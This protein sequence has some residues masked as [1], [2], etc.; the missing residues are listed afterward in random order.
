MIKS[1]EFINFRNIKGK[2]DF[3]EN[4]NVVIGPNNSGKSNLLDGIRLAFSAITGEYF[5]LSQSDFLDSDDTKNIEIKVELTDGA[6]PTF[7]YYCDSS[8]KKCGFIVNIKK[9]QSGRYV[10]EISL[11]NGSNVDYDILRD[12]V[13]IPNVYMIPLLR[14]DEIYTNGLTTGI[15]KFIESEEKYQSLKQ[16]SKNK[17][18]SLLKDKVTKFQDL[19]QKFDQ[20]LDIE[21]SEPKISDEKV[22]IV[23]N[24]QK[25]HN[26]KIGSGY[27][28][29]ANIILN[30]MND[31]Y[32][33]ILIDEI[34][35]HLHPSLIRTLIRELREIIDINYKKLNLNDENIKK[36]DVFL[37]PGR[38]E[39]LMS[40]KIILVEGYTEELL[41][42]NYLYSNNYNWSI[43]NVAG[44]M[45]EPYIE[46]ALYLNKKLVVISDNDKANSSNLEYSPRF[47]K[48]Q[49]LCLSK[50]V[51]LLEIDNTLETDLFENGFLNE[52][53]DL[54][55]S[56]KNHEQIKI[57]KPKCKIK[58]AMKLIEN[59]VN[60][61][62]W[63]VIE[64]I[65]NEFEGN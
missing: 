59:K 23:E 16:E 10:K 31:N 45:F 14:I 22:Y 56:H 18:K 2:Y 51:T 13:K 41:L 19:C 44:V 28:S 64:G 12:D 49:S 32:N 30:T 26:Y 37:T 43:I 24:G 1:I 3:S 61:D 35:N 63:H 55:E 20:N 58:I 17:I 60:L 27:R 25:E 9:T 54:L 40:N 36:L 65:K 57:A 42:K 4:L 29:I 39:L 62:K 21:L 8:N 38:N 34:E 53:M 7:D 6:I 33:I 47:N 48:L 11:L 46:L 52:C 15:S 5:K 50:S